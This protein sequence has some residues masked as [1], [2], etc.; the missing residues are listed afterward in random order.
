M[1]PFVLLA[2]LALSIATAG[3]GTTTILTNDM[4]G[5]ITVNG[6]VVGRGHGEITKRGPWGDATVV[7]QA[8]DGR[9]ARRTISRSFTATTFLLGFACW[10]FCWE[11]PDVVLVNLDTPSNGG[12]GSAWGPVTGAPTLTVDPWLQAPR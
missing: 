4:S 12:N 2:V 5:R 9:R 6:E 8:P 11:Y 10:L 1:R 7:V 3:C